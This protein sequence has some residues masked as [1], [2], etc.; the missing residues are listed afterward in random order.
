MTTT[1]K[2]QAA[3]VEPA[4]TDKVSVAD[5]L[6]EMEAAKKRALAESEL[7]RRVVFSAAVGSASADDI[8]AARIIGGKWGWNFDHDVEA[9]KT[10][11]RIDKDYPD[12]QDAAISERWSALT[13]HVEATRSFEQDARQKL[14]DM[15]KERQ[16]LNAR[17]SSAIA[18]K[19][20]RNTIERERPHLFSESTTA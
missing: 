8:Q 6:G 5:V 11:Q 19:L 10:L 17:H 14:R 12:G 4:A 15:E 16:Q 1:I 2:K 18:D 9:A 3:K 7:Y 20:L 13:K